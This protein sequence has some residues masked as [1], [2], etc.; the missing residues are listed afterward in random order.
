MT[1]ATLT[2]KELQTALRNLKDIGQTVIKLN[3]TT[4]NL[5]KEYDRLN[6]PKTVKIATG[7]LCNGTYGAWVDGKYDYLTEHQISIFGAKDQI[8]AQNKLIDDVKTQLKSIL[9]NPEMMS[10]L[11]EVESNDNILELRP[12]KTMSWATWLNHA[13]VSY[14]A[15]QL[16][17]SQETINKAYQLAK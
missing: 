9:N 12:K 10:K 17:E 1:N 16:I 4:E 3:T 15:V 11:N 5:Q 6:A 13:I 14:T 8:D 2:R 7:K